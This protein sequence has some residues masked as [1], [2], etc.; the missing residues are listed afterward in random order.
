MAF[1]KKKK[2]T[3]DGKLIKQKAYKFRVY[4]NQ[5]QLKILPQLFGNVRFFYILERIIMREF[6]RRFFSGSVTMV[7]SNSGSSINLQSYNDVKI[8]GSGSK[9]SFNSGK[10]VVITN[11]QITIDGVVTKLE[12]KD[13]V[14]N[15]TGDVAKLDVQVGNVVVN[16]NVNDVNISC[17]DMTCG[18]VSGDVKNSCGD[19]KCG[20]VGGSVKATCGDVSIKD[21]SVK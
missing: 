2:V 13:I 8:K 17:G 12:G 16:G 20:T 6:F 18:D 11:S 5:N 10:S 15:L 21:S 1:G 4:P 14:I 19:I 7:Q 3:E 9:Y